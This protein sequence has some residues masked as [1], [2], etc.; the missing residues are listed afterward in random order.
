[1][2][3]LNAIMRP[4]SLAHCT[5]LGSSNVDCQWLP[6][7]QALIVALKVV[8]RDSTA[9]REAEHTHPDQP[10]MLPADSSLS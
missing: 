1:M 7:S 2:A 9:D 8:D 6:F 3:A 5:A 10:Q 4:S